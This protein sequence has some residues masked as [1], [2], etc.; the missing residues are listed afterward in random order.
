MEI[1]WRSGGD[2]TEAD[3]GAVSGGLQSDRCKPARWR[4]RA[5][6]FAAGS[7]A[8]WMPVHVHVHVHVLCACVMCMCYVH[9]H[10]HVHVYGHLDALPLAAVRALDRPVPEG[11]A[12]LLQPI[13]PTTY[14]GGDDE[15]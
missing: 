15:T 10:V 6:V 4:R 13:V 2:Q 1:G 11:L 7:M 3:R 9:V 5:A 8:T 12:F 14:Q